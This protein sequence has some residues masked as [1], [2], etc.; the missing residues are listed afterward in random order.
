MGEEW[1][2]LTA[3]IEQAEQEIEKEK[4]RIVQI[5]EIEQKLETTFQNWKEENKND[6][7]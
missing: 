7:E 6:V 4:Q 2:A 3:A 5:R 1:R